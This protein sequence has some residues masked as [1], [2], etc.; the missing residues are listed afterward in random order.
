MHPAPEAVAAL[1]LERFLRQ[2][3]ETELLRFT[4][5]GSVYDGKSTLIGRLLFD[6]KGAYE[7]QIASVRKAT[8]ASHAGP[9]DF[10][11]LI[12]GLR[13]ERE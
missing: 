11:L 12:D 13:A 4:T 2:S 6:S 8:V 10:S 3:E 7:D 9:I 5:A 1:D